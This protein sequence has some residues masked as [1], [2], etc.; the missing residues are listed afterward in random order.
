[1]VSL[2][3]VALRPIVLAAAMIFAA[4][5]AVAAAPTTAPLTGVCGLAAFD[6]EASALASVYG[7][8]GEHG[9]AGDHCP[10]C[11]HA[12]ATA[13]PTPQARALAAPHAS[14][15]DRPPRYA[16]GGRR[17]ARGPPLGAQAPPSR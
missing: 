9:D 3:R 6:D 8:P 2:R 7:A 5:Q 17:Q 14:L 15:V 1:M 16:G 11:G 4:A 10:G 13:A 12:D